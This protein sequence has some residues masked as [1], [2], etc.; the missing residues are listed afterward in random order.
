M[1]Y[2]TRCGNRLFWRAGVGCARLQGL[3]AGSPGAQAVGAGGGC[4]QRMQAVIRAKAVGSLY[5][6]LQPV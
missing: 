3:D 1:T 4:R 5:G 6:T 2:L